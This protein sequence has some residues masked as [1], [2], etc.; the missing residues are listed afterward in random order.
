ML[1]SMT[2]VIH[3]KQ[4]PLPRTVRVLGGISFLNDAASDM[5]YPLLPLFLTQTLGAGAAS[6][7]IIEGVAESSVSFFKLFSGVLSDRFRNRKT[8]IVAGYGAS[9]LVR[10]LIAFATAWPAPLH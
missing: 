5:I 8:W 6:L 4:P 2:P 3:S 1:Q 7:G 10:P 9:N